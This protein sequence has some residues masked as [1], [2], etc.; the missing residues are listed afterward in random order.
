M[1]VTIRLSRCG[2]RNS[3][4]YRIVAADQRKP[5]AGKSIEVLGSYDPKKTTDKI[6]LDKERFDY[7]VSK[8]ARLSPTMSQLVK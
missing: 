7:W 4:F 5:A 8:G 1:S 3:P 6:T 2:K